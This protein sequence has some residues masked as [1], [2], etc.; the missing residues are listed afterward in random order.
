MTMYCG[1]E[2]GLP[3]QNQQANQRDSV[4]V[5][6]TIDYEQVQ[7]SIFVFDIK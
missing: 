4:H 3:I 6:F 2:N 5:V 1:S 7:S